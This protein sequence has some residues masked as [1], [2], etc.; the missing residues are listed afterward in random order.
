M[1]I[2]AIVSLLQN[3]NTSLFDFFQE[4]SWTHYVENLQKGDIS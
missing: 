3:Y 4:D 1:Y 2:K